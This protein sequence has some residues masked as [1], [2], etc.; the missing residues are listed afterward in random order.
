M[1]KGGKAPARK[2]ARFE[3]RVVEDQERIGRMAARL[4]QGGGEVVDVVAIEACGD[5]GF[6]CTLYR[7]ASHVWMIQC[8]TDG[9]MSPLEREQ[10]VQRAKTA[11]AHPLMA[12]KNGRVIEYKEIR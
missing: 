9:S 2:G 12:F 3:V 4:R 8:K 10:L 6:S 7:Q 1:T 11:G 5:V